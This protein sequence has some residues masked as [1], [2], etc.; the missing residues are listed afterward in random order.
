MFAPDHIA[1]SVP[2]LSRSRAFFEMLGGEVTSL[3]SDKFLEI[4]L[5]RQILHILAIDGGDPDSKQCI[6][7]FAMR[8]PNFTALTELCAKL[9][10]YSDIKQYAPFRIQDSPP[11]GVDGQVERNPPLK[12]LYFRDPNGILIEARCYE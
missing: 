2:N 10:S 9:N 5:G 7:H 1:L 8:V 3:P 6:H 12:A 4:T 11:M